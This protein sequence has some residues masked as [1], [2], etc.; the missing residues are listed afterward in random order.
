MTRQISIDMEHSER[1]I[2]ANKRIGWLLVI[3]VSL[4]PY[5]ALKIGHF[6]PAELLILLCFLYEFKEYHGRLGPGKSDISKQ[7]ST[8]I[9]L[10]FIGT[11][12]NMF[13][14][15]LS[16]KAVSAGFSSIWF[17]M[18]SYVFILLTLLTFGMYE[19]AEVCRYTADDILQGVVLVNCVAMP[20][21]YLLSRTRMTLFGMPLLYYNYFT[22]LATNLHHT[23]MYLLPLSFATIYVAETRYSGLK[24]LCLW[25]FGVFFMYLAYS[26][27]STKALI[28]IVVGSVVSAFYKMNSRRG[29]TASWTKIS[30][31]FA[32]F[33]A[34]LYFILHYSSIIDAGISFFR[35]NDIGGGRDLIWGL[36]LDKW[37]S[38][39]LV[40]YGF[41]SHV[42]LG[43]HFWDA[44]NTLLTVLLQTGLVG[45]LVYVV[46]WFHIIRYSFHNGYILAMNLSI[47]V[48]VT[49]G[50][51]LRRIPCWSFIIISYYIEEQSRSRG[52]K[53][54]AA[55]RARVAV[56][57]KNNNYGGTDQ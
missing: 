46:L 51:V 35:Q 12:W 16:G 31:V 47:L 10:C 54:L 33:I 42:E 34:V 11:M 49:G 44:H 19:N 57:S 43:T 39:P 4:M 24:K 7:F 2:R 26:T 3:S 50:D 23:S 22:P 55:A 20:V 37:E 48:Y 15:P 32:V 52:M 1:K 45:L 30:I 38:S 13:W 18:M 27:G 6:G 9:I 53:E 17:D 21:L 14:S 25:I 8:Y 29:K 41:G 28:G 36:A 56:D 40:G 5:T